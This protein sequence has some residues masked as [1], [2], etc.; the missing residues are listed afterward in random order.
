MLWNYL[1]RLF[2]ITFVFL[3]FGCAATEKTADTQIKNEPR[4]Q[5][6]SDN[7]CLDQITGLMWQMTLSKKSFSSWQEANQY[8]Q[9]LGIGGH[10]D[11]RLPTYDE[12]YILHDL[13][14]KRQN[15]NCEM[16]KEK[17]VW[18]KDNK[19]KIKAGYWATYITCGGVD[20]GFVKMKHGDI[21]AIRP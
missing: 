3:L 6:I 13:L 10:N 7:I 2:C 5:K 16:K 17:A 20:Y 8:V 15:N 11:W 21:R 14:E 18:Y 12:L 19:G 4:L 9:E 1:A